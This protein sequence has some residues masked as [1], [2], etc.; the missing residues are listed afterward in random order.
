MYIGAG[1]GD[2]SAQNG[3]QS[4]SDTASAEFGAERQPAKGEEGLLFRDSGYGSQGM[5]PGLGQSA[6]MTGYQN[7]NGHTVSTN[8]HR[9]TN[10]YQ[11]NGSHAR[12]S[13][14]EMNGDI[15]GDFGEKIRLGKVLNHSE[16]MELS[17]G[18]ATKALRRMKE[19]RR[20]SAASAASKGKGKAI[21]MGEVGRAMDVLNIR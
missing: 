18:E 16:Q 13:S 12:K 9:Q 21:D 5:L 1:L 15:V 2:I 7:A 11:K 8:R 20:S 6:P 19:R 4:D 17:E 3:Y 14:V 10:A